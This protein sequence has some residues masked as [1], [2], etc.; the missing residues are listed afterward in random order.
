MRILMVDDDR[1]FTEIMER[2]LAK[3]GHEVFK[4]P[5]A[6]HAFQILRRERIDALLADEFMPRGGS[7]VLLLE[8][9]HATYPSIALAL[10]GGAPTTDAILRATEV[11]ARVIT[12]GAPSEVLEFLDEA[13]ARRNSAIHDRPGGSDPGAGASGSGIS[14]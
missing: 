7:G 6:L 1:E 5:S 12:K 11:D 2:L 10:L 3:H 4:A 13:A 14:T 8:S 9:V